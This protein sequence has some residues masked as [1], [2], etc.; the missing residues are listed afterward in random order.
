VRQCTGESG[1]LV[2]RRRKPLAIFATNHNVQIGREDSYIV[3]PFDGLLDEVGIFGRALSA[4]E[5][6]AI[7]SAGVRA[8]VMWPGYIAE[9][10]V[11]PA[12]HP[13]V[14]GLRKTYKDV[15]VDGLDLMFIKAGFGLLA[16]RRRQNHH[17]RDLRGALSGLALSSC[18]A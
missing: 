18:S 17:D 8:S 10:G 1:E 12:Y 5:V 7:Y 6:Q 3:R 16:Q 11:P 13:R 2:D 15:V 4:S 14:R 9:V